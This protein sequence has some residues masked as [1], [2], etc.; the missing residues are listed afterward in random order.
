M[1]WAV[2]FGLLA[3]AMAVALGL[4]ALG[5]KRY[6]KQGPLGSPFTAMA[7][8]F[9][10]AVYK[11]KTNDARDDRNF[12]TSYAPLECHLPNNVRTLARTNQFRYISLL[13]QKLYF[14]SQNQCYGLL[15]ILYSKFLLEA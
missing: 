6:R 11:R 15:E 9:V 8:V 4:F 14:I 12:E 5:T 2:G 10:A 13:I 1:G 7:Q 3:G